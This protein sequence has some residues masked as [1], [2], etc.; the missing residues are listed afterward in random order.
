VQRRRCEEAVAAVSGPDRGRRR[1]LTGV[2]ED[3]T[4]VVVG[5]HGTGRMSRDPDRLDGDR[6]R[7]Q[8]R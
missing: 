2:G 4:L 6:D 8:N 5:S 3:A 7:A 1:R